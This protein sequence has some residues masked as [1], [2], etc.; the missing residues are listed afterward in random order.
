MAL[1]EGAEVVEEVVEE[2]GRREG[3]DEG[4]LEDLVSGTRRV[5]EV[6]VG[7]TEVEVEY[8]ME[9]LEGVVA[10]EEE[11]LANGTMKEKT[12]EKKKR[13]L[14]RKTRKGKKGGETE[15]VDGEQE[16]SRSM[17]SKAE[18]EDRLTDKKTEMMVD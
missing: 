4:V 14:R 2:G 3:E 13:R 8:W 12:R 16:M 1:E 7:A 11:G 5:E 6:V 18:K 15:R 9:N 10:L 17:W